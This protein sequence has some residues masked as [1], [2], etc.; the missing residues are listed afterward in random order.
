VGGCAWDG[1]WGGDLDSS[2]GTSNCYREERQ[3]QK[4]AI[5][6]DPGILVLRHGWGLEPQKLD[7]GFGQYSKGPLDV[8]AMRPESRSANL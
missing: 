3:G 5:C 7:R 1:G 4:P 6:P 2:L 8:M